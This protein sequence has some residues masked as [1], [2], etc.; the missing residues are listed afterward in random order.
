MSKHTFHS[1]AQA[2]E[3]A[4]FH[5]VDE[6]LVIRFQE[7]HQQE[8]DE[9]ALAIATGIIDRELLDELLAIEITPKT[10]MAFSLFPAVFVAWANGF[11]EQAEREAVLKAAHQQGIIAGCPAHELLES[12]LQKKP[13]AELVTAWKDFIHA[14]RP[15][16][17][18][19]AF[20]E[21]QDAAMKRAYDIAEA[22]GG[23]LKLLSVS[24]KEKTTLN[25]LDAVF[26]DA[27]STTEPATT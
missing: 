8:C 19:S 5:R 27:A 17:S 7:R 9:D 1:R 26:A 20:R 13:T 2:L 4:F 25:E 3:D 16:I 11:V 10:L 6:E 14:I 23:F 22:A 21:L 12:W 18:A 24:A 15:T